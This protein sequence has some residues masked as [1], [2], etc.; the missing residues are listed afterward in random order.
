MPE[1]RKLQM[2]LFTCISA[3]GIAF[4]FLFD[5]LRWSQYDSPSFVG[6]AKLI[7]GLDGGYDY[8]GRITKPLSLLLPGILEYLF[9]LKA[10]YGFIIQ[11]CLYFLIFPFVL[12][13]LFL[14]YFK[15]ESLAFWGVIAFYGFHPFAMFSLYI[16]TDIT[17]WFWG[18]L[19][20]YYYLYFIKNQSFNPY[21]AVVLCIIF[22]LGIFHK[23]S[24][25]IAPLF[26]TFDTLFNSKNEVKKNLFRLI[27][28]GAASLV[29][30]AVGLYITQL[31]FENTIIDRVDKVRSTYGNFDLL[32]LK[33]L[34]QLYHTFDACWILF[35]A[36]I[37]ENQRTKE[38][39]AHLIFLFAFTLLVMPFVYPFMIDRLLFLVAP[40][41]VIFY[42]QG[43][44]H[45]FPESKH[46]LIIGLS[47][48]QLISTYL[49]YS[50]GMQHVLP[51]SLGI[52]IILIGILWF[53]RRR[54]PTTQKSP[55]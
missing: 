47:T 33:N 34:Q 13:K 15:K 23:E 31:F 21:R 42:I 45:Y 9:G 38:I 1:G 28:I 25:V 29:L 4:Y 8:Q 30:L 14:Y 48:I 17:G 22:V 39:P 7:F 55:E 18:A 35:F 37:W 11:N 6:G 36:G 16:L 54:K 46:V 53:M 50:Q 52:S 19:G 32:N 26:F 27:G 2:L 12:F 44:D 5:F 3:M 41:F 10:Q 40:I 20:I 51:Y 49:I 43:L 24:A